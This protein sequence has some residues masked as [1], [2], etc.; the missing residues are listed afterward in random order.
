MEFACKN[1]DI[2]EVVRC[3]L[4]LTKGDYKILKFLIDNQS[5]NLIQRIF[6]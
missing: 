6:L 5:K 4:G 2:E 3:G 1:F